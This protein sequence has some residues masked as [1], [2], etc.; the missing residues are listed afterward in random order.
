MTHQA[1]NRRSSMQELL[2]KVSRY[3]ALVERGKAKALRLFCK[4][5]QSF[6]ELDVKFL[7]MVC[8]FFHR[9][10]HMLW[11]RQKLRDLEQA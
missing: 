11:E 3:E 2:A 7:S 8:A 1:V 10:I 6:T 9:K 4:R 5:R